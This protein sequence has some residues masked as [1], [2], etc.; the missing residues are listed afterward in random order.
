MTHPYD[1]APV[2]DAQDAEDF[3]ICPEC[4]QDLPHHDCR[5]TIREQNDTFRTDAALIGER[6][7][8]DQLVITRGVA[9]LGNAFID[10]AMQA[11]RAFSGFTEESD[12]WGEHDFGAFDLDGETLNWK[13]DA[14]DNELKYGS[15]DPRDP[16]QTRRVLTVLLAGEY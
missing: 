9:A 7:A 6:I 5:P 14:Y 15:P 4:G 2:R 10:R 13:I 3:T 11:V 8:R 16:A 1:E 12:P